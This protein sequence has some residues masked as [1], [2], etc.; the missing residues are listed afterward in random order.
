[1]D[2]VR[3]CNCSIPGSVSFVPATKITTTMKLNVIVRGHQ[4][5]LS[6]KCAICVAYPVYIWGYFSG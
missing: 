4:Q 3:W 2:A 6:D 5:E 1:M